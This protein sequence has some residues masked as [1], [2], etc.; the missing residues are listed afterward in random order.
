M[1]TNNS[2]TARYLPTGQ[3]GFCFFF[4]HSYGYEPVCPA[5]R[6]K[7]PTHPLPRLLHFEHYHTR[8]FEIVQSYPDYKAVTL[9]VQPQF[10][11]HYYSYNQ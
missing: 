7:K 5:G 10:L 8:L 1:S 9:D 4:L 3:A 11:S 6:K 2:V